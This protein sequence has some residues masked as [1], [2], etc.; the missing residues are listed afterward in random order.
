MT[1]ENIPAKFL[2]SI[3]GADGLYEIR[4]EESSNI[5]RIFCCFDNGNLIILFNGFQKKSQKTPK[6]EIEK[7]Q[8]I[9]NEYFNEKR[10]SQ[11]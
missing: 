1:I 8:R 3:N 6:G 7:A 10:K 4:I 11:I 2:K 5:Y 9:M